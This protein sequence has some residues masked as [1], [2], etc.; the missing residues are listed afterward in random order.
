[1][2]EHGGTADQVCHAGGRWAG[3]LCG[4]GRAVG[5]LCGVGRPVYVVLCTARSVMRKRADGVSC[6]GGWLLLVFVGVGGVRLTRKPAGAACLGV[7]C[8]QDFR[9][10]DIFLEVTDFFILGRDVCA[11]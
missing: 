10:I 8:R 11:K 6:G 3:V 4:V 7:F 1:V 9:G 2:V 5:E